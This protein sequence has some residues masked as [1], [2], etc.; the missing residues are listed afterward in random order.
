VPC[1]QVPNEHFTVQ[2]GAS[3]ELSEPA[4][5]V[6]T[7]GNQPQTDACDIDIKDTLRRIRIAAK[8][9]GEPPEITRK[10]LDCVRN[11][12]LSSGNIV[13]CN[14]GSEE[15]P[16]FFSIVIKKDWTLPF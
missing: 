3:N 5:H 11:S 12:D 2:Q 9:N 16:N 1:A 4:R 6:T 7:V 14:I 8:I 13:T 10:K 15:S